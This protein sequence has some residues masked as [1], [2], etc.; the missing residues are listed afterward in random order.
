MDRHL[1][2][3]IEELEEKH[4]F[5]ANSLIDAI[6]VVDLKTLKFEYITPSIEKISGYSSEQYLGFT[7]ADR[8]SPESFEHVKKM[9]DET[10]TDYREGKK[11]ED[12]KTV[13]LEMTHQNCC[14]LAFIC[15]ARKPSG[16][17]S[18]AFC[19]LCSSPSESLRKCLACACEK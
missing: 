3:K 18:S 17:D 8:L 7:I 5:I 2:T 15:S 12:F 11:Y 16:A 13:E 14:R 10:V 6:W 19:R 4:H 1:K 9:I